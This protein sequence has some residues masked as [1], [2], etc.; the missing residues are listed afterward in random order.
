M[1]TCPLCNQH[2]VVP[3]SGRLLVQALSE[4]LLRDHATAPCFQGAQKAR[5]WRCP[6]CPGGRRNYA[7]SEGLAKHLS[8]E[9]TSATALT[10][11]VPTPQPASVLRP[12][13]APP[14]SATNDP[15]QPHKL[16]SSESP[17]RVPCLPW[18]PRPKWLL[19][20]PSATLLLATWNLEHFSVGAADSGTVARKVAHIC[21]TLRTLCSREGP[22]ASVVVAL[23]EVFCS[24]AV[25]FLASYL[26]EKD[27]VE[28]GGSGRV[29]HGVT[30][31]PLGNNPERAAFLW[32]GPPPQQPPQRGVRRAPLNADAS[33]GFQ[34]LRKE[35][36]DTLIGGQRAQQ[37]Q[38][39]LDEGK[40][41]G[42]RFIRSPFYGLF[43]VGYAN[44]LLV[45]VHL[46]AEAAAARS[47]LSALHGL[48]NAIQSP[49]CRLLRRHSLGGRLRGRKPRGMV[50]ILG[51]FNCPISRRAIAV[52]GPATPPP[53]PPGTLPGTPPP[54]AARGGG[55]TASETKPA[56]EALPGAAL[57]AGCPGP[58]AE[59]R[60]PGSQQRRQR[61]QELS[62]TTTATTTTPQ[63]GS[64]QGANGQVHGGGYGGANGPSWEAFLRNGWINAL[65]P[66]ANDPTANGNCNGNGNGQGLPLATNW[67]AK[68]LK[69]L[70]AI[71]LPQTHGSL[72]TGR[73]VCP[74]PAQVDSSQPGWYPNHLLCWVRLDLG[75]LQMAPGKVR[76]LLAPARL[77]APAA[78]AA[79]GAVS[80][81]GSGAGGAAAARAR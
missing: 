51:D 68:Q 59:G 36:L 47:E 30:S 32:A 54:P 16:E 39:Q 55:S 48:A 60:E 45:N 72:V 46:A 5:P 53:P 7:S 31:E 24:R 40:G 67:R 52:A 10:A 41:P 81:T 43:R 34:L 65:C 28:R 17:L 12:A 21:E 20:P 22:H 63:R 15:I 19:R 25:S 56:G 27:A 33:S 79:T 1:Q 74:P 8:Q 80:G 58:L 37:Q 76:P 23:Q 49:N 75:P 64:G 71:C 50:A 18:L 9:H 4:H 29:W 73:G 11:D 77:A 70:D 35:D 69:A 2:Q 3:T 66:D 42:G 26:T 61:L 78:A 44:L 13:S 6:L 57:R 38:Q 62:P 14:A